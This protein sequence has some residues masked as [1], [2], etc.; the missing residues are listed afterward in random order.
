[1]AISI[2]IFLMYKLRK[3]ALENG[4]EEIE[5]EV[6]FGVELKRGLRK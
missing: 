1:M 3:R 5:G 4:E 2:V 6:F